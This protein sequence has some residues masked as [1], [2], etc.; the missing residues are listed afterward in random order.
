MRCYDI[1]TFVF[2]EIVCI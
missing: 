1:V 2:Q